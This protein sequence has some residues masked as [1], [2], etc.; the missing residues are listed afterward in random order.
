[1]MQ[2]EL[3]QPTWPY[4]KI[5][6]SPDLNIDDYMGGCEFS[7][8]LTCTDDYAEFSSIPNFSSVFSSEFI[9]FPGTCDDELQGMLQMEDFLELEGLDSI[10][11]DDVEGLCRSFDHESEGNFPSQVTCE[12]EGIWSPSTSMKSSEASMDSTLTLPAEEMEIDNQVSVSHLLKA[13][14]EALER[15]QRE[16]GEV[17]TKCLSEKVSPAGE[18]LERLAFNLSP[19]I[20]KQREYLMQE[21]R[22]NFKDA[23]RAFYQLFP[24]GR[25]AHFA[26]NTTILEAMPDDAEIIHIVDFDIGEGLQWP[27][28][29]EAIAKRHRTLRLTSIKRE[30]EDLTCASLPWS[31]AETRRQ[32]SDYA[33]CFGL[34]LKV[35]EMG[36]EELVSEIKRKKKRGDNKQRLVFNCMVGLPHMGRERSRKPVKE[37]LH[38]AKEL[39]SENGNSSKNRGIITLGDG[40]A[41]E[42]Q[43]YCRGFGS[44]FEGY[45]EHYQ[46]LLESIKSSFPT[47]LAEARMAMECLFVTPYISSHVWLQ[48]WEEMRQGFHIQAGIGLEKSKVSKDVLMEAGEMV[49]GEGCY[50]VR[51]GGDGENELIL[52][53]RGTPLV[54]VSTWRS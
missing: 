50:G 33:R 38:T 17:I 35:E 11:S 40:D 3:V 1:M 43:A 15:G 46:A 26:A 47:H 36:I 5:I 18:A 20:E 52:E 10:L 24:Y 34:K 49:K 29:M 19:D 28:L 37:F 54:R 2:P 13:Y 25:I 7:S 48:K 4:Y 42:R 23:F 22:K 45:L 31:F 39:L 27:P 53:W 16:L 8:S 41:C 9:Q 30:D 14:G 51:I 44:F 32:L 12:R 21:S 6:N